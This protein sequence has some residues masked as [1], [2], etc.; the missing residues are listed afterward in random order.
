MAT[1]PAAPANAQRTITK[2]ELRTQKPSVSD[3][4]L[5]DQLWNI[6]RKEDRRRKQRPRAALNDVWL[7][8]PAYPT[9]VPNLCRSDQVTMRLAPAEGAVRRSDADTPM[10]AYGL[11]ASRKYLFLKLPAETAA[12]RSYDPQDMWQGRCAR[13][14]V[15]DVRFFLAQDEDMAEGGYRALLRAMRAAKNGTLV[16]KCDLGPV[17]RLSCTE[18][19]VKVGANP[20]D[21]IET[22]PAAEKISCYQISGFDELQVRVSV[23]KETEALIAVEIDQM[24]IVADLRID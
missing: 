6:F 21:S 7:E 4:E 17:N 1:V 18:A 9:A 13:L 22:C 14:A 5:R 11:D 16:P 2:A 19:L 8:T 15:D 10:R 12:D 3:A 23:S 24:I 20:I